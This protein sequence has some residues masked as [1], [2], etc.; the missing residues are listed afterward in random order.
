[1]ICALHTHPLPAVPDRL[2][3][4][5]CE[6]PD[7]PER[8]PAEDDVVTGDELVR[9]AEVEEESVTLV[10]DLVH[11]ADCAPEHAYVLGPKQRW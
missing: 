9:D 6:L 5:D 4:R 8:E 2:V 3:E 7:C 10:D 11:N 1:M